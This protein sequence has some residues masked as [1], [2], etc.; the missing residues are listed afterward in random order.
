[1]GDTV[2]AVVVTFNRK[3][4]LLTNITMLK[5][6]TRTLDR[7]MILDNCSTDGTQEFLREKGLLDDDQI[8]YICLESNIGGAGGFS[9]GTKRAYEKGYDYAWL[10][11]DDGHPNDKYCLETIMECADELRKRNPLLMLNSMVTDHEKLS[12]GLMGY[13]TVAELDRKVSEEVLYDDIKPFNGT[14]VSR[15]LIEKIGYPDRDFFIKGDEA[16]YRI[17][18]AEAGAVVATVRKSVYYH[19]AQTKSYKKLFGKRFKV[20]SES[21]WKE[22]YRTRNHIHIALMHKQY[23]RIKKIFRQQVCNV[24]L[25]GEDTGSKIKMF[26]RGLI[27]GFAGRMGIRVNP[28]E[29]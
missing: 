27:D 15:K 13:Q 8:N 22:Y 29:K 7:I 21:P 3:E 11:D 14:L 9:E 19:P 10:M 18:A 24:L 23:G 17:R 5:G 25:S 26:F 4:E 6:Q 12:F 2:A 1:M 16:D 28:G 20:V